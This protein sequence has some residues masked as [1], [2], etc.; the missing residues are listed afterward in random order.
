MQPVLLNQGIGSST[1]KTDNITVELHDATTPFATVAT[2]TGTLNT[3][4]TVSLT[5][6]PITGSYYIAVKHRNSLQTW[7][8]NPVTVGQT[9]VLYDFS[10]AAN[11]AYGNNMIQIGA[12]WALYTGDINQDEFIDGFDYP[13]FDND[14]LSGVTGV[15]STTDM[16]GDGF[17]DGF[18]YPVFDNNNINGIESIHP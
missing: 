7:S 18:D 4:G 8:A 17:V 13:A 1:S 9:P 11:K 10:M 3:D 14:N 2:T 5:F 15:Y 16:N 6:T 12:V